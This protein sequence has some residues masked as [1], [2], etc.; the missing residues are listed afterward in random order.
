MKIEKERRGSTA[1]PRYKKVVRESTHVTKLRRTLKQREDW[2]N[3]IKEK[4]KAKKK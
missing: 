4:K 2:Q 3:K 1:A